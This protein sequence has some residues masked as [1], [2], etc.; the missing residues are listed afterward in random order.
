MERLPSGLMG[1]PE[2][3]NF[4]S[5]ELIKFNSCRWILLTGFCIDDQEPFQNP[6]LVGLRLLKS[7]KL[8][9]LNLENSGYRPQGVQDFAL[10]FVKRFFQKVAKLTAKGF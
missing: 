7:A 8:V 4:M 2:E 5:R 10:H 6:F 3:F 9:T 1:E